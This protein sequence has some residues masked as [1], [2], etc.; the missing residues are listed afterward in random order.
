MFKKLIKTLNNNCMII[1][2]H[3]FV[4]EIIYLM[5]PFHWQQADIE[6][7][8]S[9]LFQF[10]AIFSAIVIT[11][12]ISK[13]FSQRQENFKRK[14][15]IINLSNKVS[16][17]RRISRLLIECNTMWPA[18]LKRIINNDYKELTYEIYIDQTHELNSENDLLINRFEADTRFNKQIGRFLLALKSIQGDVADKG[19]FLYTNYDFH[20]TY[21]LKIVNAWSSYNTANCLYTTLDHEYSS[22]NR[23]LLLAN[24]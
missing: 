15:E 24:I 7:S 11:A 19:L 5:L 10:S 6:K 17:L 2:Y 12:I 13:V 1:L 18:N 21:S 23:Q 8:Y 9:Y 20:Y 14:E 4:F 3:I 22:L 16:D